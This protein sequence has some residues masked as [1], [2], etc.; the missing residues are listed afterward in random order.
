M[1]HH[2]GSAPDSGAAGARRST[3]SPWA[4]AA[5]PERAMGQRLVALT[6]RD[7]ALVWCSPPTSLLVAAGAAGSET[8]IATRKAAAQE[9]ETVNQ[10][11]A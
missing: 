9:A 11:A 8:M 5:D 1:A 3:W 2:D 7:G 4:R 10:R 6:A